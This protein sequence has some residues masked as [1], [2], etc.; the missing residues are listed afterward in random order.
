[1]VNVN[2]TWGTDFI[3]SPDWL[4]LDLALPSTAVIQCAFVGLSND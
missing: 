1:M 3:N 4:N 2:P